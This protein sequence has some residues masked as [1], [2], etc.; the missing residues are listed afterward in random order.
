MIMPRYRD[1]LSA[2]VT[3]HYQ[4][5][6][7]VTEPNRYLRYINFLLKNL[8]YRFKKP[9]ITIGNGKIR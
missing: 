2:A 5:L 4:P 8:K 1:S 7:T 3:D 9:Y 6:L